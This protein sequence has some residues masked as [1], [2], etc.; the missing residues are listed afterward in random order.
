MKKALNS[1]FLIGFFVFCGLILAL[2]LRG[3]GGNPGPKELNSTIWRED[4]P[5][6]L[7]PERGRFAL[8]YSIAENH[9]FQFSNDIGKFAIPDVAISKNKYV[10]LFAPF[11]S[12]ITTPGYI[13]GKIFGVSQVGTFAV[14]SIFAIINLIL[15]RSIAI[16]LGANPIPSIIGGLV[17]LFA[18]PAFSYAV[19]LYQHHVS[20]FLLLLSIY[21]LLKSNKIW[22]QLLV[23]LLCGISI[24]LDYPNFFMMFPIGIYALN[25][26]ISIQKISN[27]F[28]I[29]INLYK[30]LAILVII[31]PIAFF[32]WFNYESYGN[33]FQLSGTLQTAKHVQDPNDL[34]S[35]LL[36]QKDAKDSKPDKKSAVGFFRTRNLVNGFYIHFISP[37]R[38]IVYYTPIVLFGIIGLVLALRKKPQMV[39]LLIAIMGANI[40]LYSMW[41][42]PYGGWAFGSR[43][44]IP[45]YAILSIFVALFLTFW[46]KKYFLMPIFAFVAFYSIVVNTLGAITTSANPPQVEVLDLEKISGLIQKYTYERNWNFLMTGHSKSFVYQTF[47]KD[48]IS[49]FGFFFILAILICAFVTLLLIL[50]ISSKGR[51]ED[52]VSF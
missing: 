14:I 37:D 2:S 47:L 44:L 9:S 32:L 39:P 1:L 6:E 7:S 42:D 21:L 46:R 16:R 29:K 41:G 22:S 31:L 24:P 19:N 48:Y 34:S 28:S 11:L 35:I 50:N 18:T 17:F 36:E 13:I 26:S 23:F 52:N 30:I 4:G 25:R 5:F 12:F 3:L 51:I 43:Y 27:R 20:L 33:P 8:L 45:S 49:T 10:S 15:I 38:G 40:L